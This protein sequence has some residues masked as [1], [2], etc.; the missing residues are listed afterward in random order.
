MSAGQIEL[1]HRGSVAWIT[2]SNPDKRN[3]MS[4][5]MWQQLASVLADVSNDTRC[6]VLRGAGE[7]AF[8]S[9]ADISE[10]EALRSSQQSMQTYDAAAEAATTRLQSMPQPTVA[11]ISGYCVGGG[12]ALALCCDVRLATNTSQY[13]VD[14]NNT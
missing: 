8:V 5:R 7:K 11:M 3:A 14:A 12:V 2:I 10:F 1:E 13:A 4:L 9:G 6:I